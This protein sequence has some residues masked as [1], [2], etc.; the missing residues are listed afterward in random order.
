MSNIHSILPL[1]SDDSWKWNKEELV[2][3]EIPAGR[4]ENLFSDPV[5][6]GFLYFGIIRVIGDAGEKTEI[7]VDFDSF[8]YKV[9]IEDAFGDGITDTGSVVPSITRYNTEDDIYAMELRPNPPIAYLDN[10]RVSI[11]APSQTTVNTQATALK[12]D[13]VNIQEFARSYQMA[14]S[15]ELIRGI[16]SLENKV[17]RLN[18]NMRDLLDAIDGDRLRNI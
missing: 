10:A 1:V 12:L 11:N 4:T 16:S 17:D 13:I 14:T 18:G 7:E 15:G 2:D 6:P 5:T 8:H 3:K 9:T